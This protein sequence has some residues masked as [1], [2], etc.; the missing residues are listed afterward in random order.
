MKQITNKTLLKQGDKTFQPVE[1]N[2]IIYWVDKDV[3]ENEPCF[4]ITRQGFLGRY[5]G[6]APELLK[7]NNG[8]IIAQ[9]H[10]KF[11]GIPV[12]SLDKNPTLHYQAQYYTQKDIEK[13]MRFCR[14]TILQRDFILE[15]I[16]QILVVEVDEQF[17]IIS[18]E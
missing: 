12:I 8:K 2:K 7:G 5:E 18:Y 13:T 10:P 3:K 1:V 17:N 9:S 4:I 6:I 15:Q 16:N 11:E 14:E